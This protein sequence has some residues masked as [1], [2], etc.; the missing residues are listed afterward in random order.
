[1]LF[2]EYLPDESPASLD[3]APAEFPSQREFCR[4]VKIGKPLV[5]LIDRA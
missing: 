3:C 4:Y 5:S 1:M 2:S